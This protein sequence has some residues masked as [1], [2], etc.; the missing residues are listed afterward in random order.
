[1]F[2]KV[3]NTVKICKF[4]RAQLKIHIPHT[5]Y[6]SPQGILQ[7]ISLVK[8]KKIMLV[9]KTHSAKA[10]RIIHWS[11]IGA[12]RGQCLCVSLSCG[13][14]RVIV[15]SLLRVTLVVPMMQD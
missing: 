5:H 4:L 7:E 9:N 13:C 15:V 8:K 14:D 1:M 12:K 2:A 3:H 10:L 11:N 6:G